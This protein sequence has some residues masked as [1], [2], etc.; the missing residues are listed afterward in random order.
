MIA[1]A[2]RCLAL[3][4]DSRP[5]HAGAVGELLS[6]H[7]EG[8]E[9]RLRQAQLAQAQA[10]AR[11][12]EERKRRRLTALLAGL[13]LALAALG[14]TSY[15]SWLKRQQ[16][17]EA[18]ALGVLRDV[19]RF[20]DAAATDPAG[21]PARWSEAEESLRRA[22]THWSNSARTCTRRLSRP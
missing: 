13:V 11:A 18:V 6:A 14:I 12:S 17:R 15:A 5:R 8:V 16:A 4:K 2:R 10:Q 7:L 1:L 22:E 21:E 19:F 20:R 9:D 3:D